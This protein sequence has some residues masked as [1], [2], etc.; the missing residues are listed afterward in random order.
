MR[1]RITEALKGHQ[2]DYLE[3][4][5]EEAEST[6]IRYRGRELEEVGRS[7]SLGGS[8]RALVNGAW[9]FAS[10]NNVE[11][12]GRYAAL[13]VEQARLVGGGDERMAE[14]PAVD[15]VAPATLR[16]D[17]RQVSLEV[18]KALLDEYNRI[19]WGR[20][21]KVQTTVVRYHDA[22]RRQWFANSDGAYLVQE[23]S[24]LTGSFLAVARDG[25]DVQ[26]AFMSVGSADDYGVMEGLHDQVAD[27][28]DQAEALL[29]AKPVRGGTY[30]VVVD[31]ALAGVFV[32][33][34]FGH[35]SEAD[36]VHE[37]PRLRELMVLGKRFGPPELNIYDG[38]A[39]PGHRGSYLYDDE[40]VAAQITPLVQDGIL[41]G[42][43]HSRATAA[44]MGEQP[45]GNA[46]AISYRHRP[47][48]RMTNT[49]LDA[50][51]ASPDEMF[52]GIKE[53]VYVIRSLGGQTS[54]EMFTFSAAKAFMIR[55]GQLAEQVRNVNLSGNLFETLLNIEA[56]GSDLTWR[57][58]GGGCGK[59]GQSPLAVGIGG[60]HVRI[61][62]VVVGG[63]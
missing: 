51:P 8:V 36:H 45:T 59:G 46:R 12:L 20:S 15:A 30:T 44:R 50:G 34:A 37:N 43:L 14:A 13:A 58:E 49:Y 39:L 29:R 60:P 11:Q 38:A 23:W 5:V 62:Q 40:G 27:V 24:D 10:F 1:D 4:R 6:S 17:P 53:G 47:L 32:H 28:A 19:L 3:I 57:P 54:M 7:E 55:D 16:R 63:E 26:Q 9:G 25:N 52:A 21:A 48:V 22:F 31:P 2:G 41:V 61:R 18:K 33:E 56:I 35:L 42:R